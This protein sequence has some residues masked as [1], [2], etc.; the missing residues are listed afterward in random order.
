MCGRFARFSPAHIFRMLFQLDEFLELAPQ[1]NIA[2]GQDVYAIRGITV[3]DEQQRTAS[4][5]DI[6]KEIAA[7]KWGLI[8]FWSKDPTI[9]NK[10]INARSET[11]AEKPAYREAF[12]KRRCLIPADGFYHDQAFELGDEAAGGHLQPT[13]ARLTL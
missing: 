2:P 9:G 6:Q 3:R 7:L 12:K 11:V 5:S 1:Y 4:I 13:L 10:M 8:P